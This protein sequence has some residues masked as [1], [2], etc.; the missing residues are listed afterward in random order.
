MP[1]T[2]ITPHVDALFIR[3]DARFAVL[4]S[5]LK[6]QCPILFHSGDRAALAFCSFQEKKSASGN[7][8]P[9][10]PRQN[11]AAKCFAFRRQ[12]ET[13]LSP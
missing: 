4:F 7:M 11:I 12:G 13:T 8:T 10:F 3:N 6:K 2:P 5:P 1:P 9:P